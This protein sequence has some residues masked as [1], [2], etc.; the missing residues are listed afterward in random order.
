MAAL[1]FWLAAQSGVAPQIVGRI[2]RGARQN[3]QIGAFQIVLIAG[4]EECGRPIAFG[5]IDLRALLQERPQRFLVA[6][7]DCLRQ[8]PP[9]ASGAGKEHRKRNRDVVQAFRPARQGGPKGPHYV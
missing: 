9:I 4:P 8:R 7:L 1:P 6:A 3:Q 5:G 2:D